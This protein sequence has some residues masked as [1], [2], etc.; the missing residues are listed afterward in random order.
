MH[1]IHC[2]KELETGAAFCPEC[3]APQQTGAQPQ[4]VEAQSAAS[5]PVV[6]KA[7]YNVLSIIGLVV[8]CISLLLN[9]YGLVGIAGTVL[10]VLGLLGCKRKRENG[11]VLAI[12]GIVLGGASI[13]YGFIAILSFL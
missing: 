3:G 7:P 1:C 8:S 9:Y 10:S 5:K 13:L 6:Q 4:P 2:G 11:R 12:T